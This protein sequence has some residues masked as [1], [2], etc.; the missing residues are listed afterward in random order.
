MSTTFYDIIFT[1]NNHIEGAQS[2]FPETTL[3]VGHPTAYFVKLPYTI[4]DLVG[5]RH[6]QGKQLY[7][8]EKTIFLSRID[9]ENFITDMCVDRWFIEQNRSLC[10][11]DDENIWHCL[12]IKRSRRNDGVLVMSAGRVFPYWAAYVKNA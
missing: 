9:Y 4:S 10:H 1:Q 12:F 7:V 11:I 8:V 2:I 5:P 3:I 6:P